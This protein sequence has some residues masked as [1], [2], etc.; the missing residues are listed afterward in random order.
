MTPLCT[1]ATVYER[2]AC[3]ELVV[4]LSMVPLLAARARDLLFSCSRE[5]FTLRRRRESSARRR[6]K[7]AL[8]APGPTVLW[9]EAGEPG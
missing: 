9:P 6:V 3:V 4:E 2:P 1:L 8:C 5:S 7:S